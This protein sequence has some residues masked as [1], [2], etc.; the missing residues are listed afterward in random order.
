MS[1]WI[2]LDITICLDY[3]SK[4]GCLRGSCLTNLLVFLE[5]VTDYIEKGYKSSYI[6]SFYY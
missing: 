6:N 5:K 3:I 4:H 1:L 2:T